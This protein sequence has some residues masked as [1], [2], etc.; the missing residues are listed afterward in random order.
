V[1]QNEVK[2]MMNKIK[3]FFSKNWKKLKEYCS[4]RWIRF[5]KFI[6]DEKHSKAV[7]PIVAVLMGFLLG[8]VIMIVTGRNPLDIFAS[9]IRGTIGIDL[10][11]IGTGKKVFN[12]RYI[13]EFFVYSMPIILTGLSVAFA[14]RTGLFNIGAE[15][16]LMAGS[17]GA[18]MVGVLVNVPESFLY[19]VPSIFHLPLAIFTG[20]LFGGLWGFIPGFLKAK[21][22]VH[23]VVV[24]IMMNY[25]AL[26]TTNFLYKQLPGSDNIRTVD[27]AESASLHS[28]FLQ[29]LTN[30]SRLH[31]GFF[32]VIIA[33]LIFW[34]IIDKTTFGFELKSAGFNKHASKYAGMKVER[35]I[36]LS[37]VIAGTFAGL[38]G[39]M[40]SIGTFDYGRVLPGAEG[41]GFDG[42]AV[43]L[44]GGTTALGSL[45]AG[46]LF[47]GL[48]NSQPLMQARGIPRDITNI[49][50]ASIVVFVA[51]QAGIKTFLKR[52]KVKENK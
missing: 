18:I 5:K 28:E 44:V 36:I 42:I 25:V 15:G 45:F 47:G 10:S 22:N 38:A 34:L 7:V 31:W 39:V 11:F 3:S 30:N 40:L 9:L 14:F 41:Y 4:V 16:Q 43:A 26:Y 33:I 17:F 27:V 20:A 50:M 2:Q 19:D 6:S 24:T 1:D 13:G 23:E 46:L 29:D 35:N 21:F 37:M 12:P 32:V 51:M 8:I 48:K 52:F 49:I